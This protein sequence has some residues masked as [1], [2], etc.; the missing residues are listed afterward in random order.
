V[1][2]NIPPRDDAD[3]PVERLGSELR[4]AKT[5]ANKLNLPL[6]KVLPDLTRF[7]DFTISLKPVQLRGQYSVPAPTYKSWGV[8]PGGKGPEAQIIEINLGFAIVLLPRDSGAL[9]EDIGEIVA[10]LARERDLRSAI[11]RREES[12]SEK[13]SSSD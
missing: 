2:A 8:E 3:P 12:R 1:V 13:K 6:Q 9:Q 5:A 11:L 4:Q 10:Q 7:K